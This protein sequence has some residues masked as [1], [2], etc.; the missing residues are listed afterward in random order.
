MTTTAESLIERIKKLSAQTGH[1]PGYIGMQAVKDARIIDKLERGAVMLKTAASLARFLDERLNQ[2]ATPASAEPPAA[3]MQASRGKP[4]A[5][6]K[7]KAKA[8][9][10]KGRRPRR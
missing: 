7:K 4:K 3:P 9:I 8:N 5:K 10:T 1:A 2:G 6:A